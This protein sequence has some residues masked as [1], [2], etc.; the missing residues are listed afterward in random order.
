MIYEFSDLTLDLDRHLLTRGGQPIKLTKLSFKVLQALVQ[1]APALIS[2]DDLIDQVWGLKRVITP[3][4]L[5]QRMKTL[6]QSLGD[7]PNR[8]VRKV[9]P[10]LLPNPL[11]ISP[12]LYCPLP[13]YLLTLSKSIFPMALPRKY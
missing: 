2:H 10:Q 7:D 11:V 8:R 5:S 9:V 4:N 12:S 3:D 1:A 6:R 13:I